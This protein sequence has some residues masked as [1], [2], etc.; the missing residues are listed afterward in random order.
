MAA[1]TGVTA[2]HEAGV[3]ANRSTV[4]AQ[5]QVQALVVIVLR[6]LVEIVRVATVLQASLAAAMIA[7]HAPPC[8]RGL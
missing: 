7:L 4:I 6:V 8:P 5:A 2:M 1:Q 3:V